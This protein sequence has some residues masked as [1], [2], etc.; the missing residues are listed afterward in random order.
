MFTSYINLV[1]YS[2]VS[3][4]S[5]R[6]DEQVQRKGDVYVQHTPESPW[7]ASFTCFPHAQ[8]HPAKTKPLQTTPQNY[9]GYTFCCVLFQ[10]LCMLEKNE[11][12]FV[13]SLDSMLCKNPDKTDSGV[14]CVDEVQQW[15]AKVIHMNLPLPSTF[16]LCCH[17]PILLFIFVLSNCH[18]PIVFVYFPPNVRPSF[19]LPL[20][21]RFIPSIPC[22]DPV[23]FL[24][25]SF[26]ASVSRSLKSFFLLLLLLP[27]NNTQAMQQVW[28]HT[29]TEWSHLNPETLKVRVRTFTCV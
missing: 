24:T 6:D 25:F 13:C 16:H 12:W 1:S 26:F 9:N 27:Q 18:L 4:T 19:H 7:L 23:S 22:P 15:I 17:L 8:L 3:F 11:I 21:P 28:C 29:Y 5:A 10:G 20:H 2:E 14:L